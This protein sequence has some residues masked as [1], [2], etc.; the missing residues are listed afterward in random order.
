ML[1]SIQN[2]VLQLL[3]DLCDIVTCRKELGSF[4][5]WSCFLDL[6]GEGGRSGERREA[7]KGDQMMEREK[8]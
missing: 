3:S 4:Y 8:T 7:G 1:L 6:R 2:A 5:R